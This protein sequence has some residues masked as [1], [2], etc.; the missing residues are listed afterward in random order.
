LSLLDIS[1]SMFA[2]FYSEFGSYE[3]LLIYT[4][5]NI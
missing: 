3:R 1:A 5:T 2:F 4:N